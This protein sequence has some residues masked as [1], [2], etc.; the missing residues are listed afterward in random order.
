[1]LSVFT[2]HYISI[3][4]TYLNDQTKGDRDTVTGSDHSLP[5]PDQQRKDNYG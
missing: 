3:K 1:M 2:F 5:L 4:K